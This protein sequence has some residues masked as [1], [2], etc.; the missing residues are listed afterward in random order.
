[1]MTFEELIKWQEDIEARVSELERKMALPDLDDTELTLTRQYGLYVDKT[2]AAQILGVTR[3]TVYAMLS[4]GRID[5]GCGGK[6][7]SVASIAR[8]L[9]SSGRQNRGEPDAEC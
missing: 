2:V 8:Y 9:H 4:D 3:A 7:V 6:K 1:M 5:S